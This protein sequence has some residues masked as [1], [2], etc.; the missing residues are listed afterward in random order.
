M[1][2]VDGRGV[3]EGADQ[4]LMPE[5]QSTMA[6][7]KALVKNLPELVEVATS[8]QPDIREIDSDHALVDVPDISIRD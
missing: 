3:R 5:P 7:F 2:P 4:P 6:Q 1:L 8:G